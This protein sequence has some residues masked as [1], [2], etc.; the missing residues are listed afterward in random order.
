M[1]RGHRPKGCA[2][3]G[4]EGRPHTTDSPHR[5]LGVGANGL[6]RHFYW[7]QSRTYGLVLVLDVHGFEGRPGLPTV[8]SLQRFRLLES[9]A[10][11]NPRCRYIAV[12]HGY[13]DR[14][15]RQTWKELT[16]SRYPYGEPL[17]DGV[18]VSPLSRG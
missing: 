10:R 8:D 11:Q 16:A 6:D 4:S 17:D 14:R 1:R 9:T 18:T 3:R 2:R 13:H 5:R 15:N 7:W 12:I